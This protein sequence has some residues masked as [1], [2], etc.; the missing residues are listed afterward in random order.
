MKQ[1]KNLVLVLV[2]VVF[3]ARAQ[4]QLYPFELPKLP[5]AYNA[6]EPAVDA[7]TMEIHYS[8]HHAAYVSN[9]NAAL[10]GTEDEEYPM[11]DLLLYA[12]EFSAAVRNNAGGHYNHTLFWN[13]LLPGKP[14]DPNSDLGKAVI[15]TFGSAESLYLLLSKA[16]STRFGSGWA[17]L[18][19]T[20][21]YQLA[22][23]STPN[24]DNP[25][26]DVSP[27]RGIPIL[28]I[29]V[30]EHA[31]Y[32]KYQNK[33]GDYLRA[34]LDIINWEAVNKNYAEALKSPVMVTIARETWK[35]LSA[36]HVVMS[37]TFHPS[38][39]GNL[40]PIRERS[41]EFLER[42]KDLQKGKIPSLLDTPAIHQSIDEL[43]T[44][45]SELNQMVSNRADD[46]TL[47]K[48]LEELH[49]VFHTIQGLCRHH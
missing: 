16:G 44:G 23:S 31:Y 8:K 37:Q 24:Q 39:E 19:V 49:D 28:G 5:Y 6:L 33:R 7:A 21:E 13:I 20:P 40:Q 26:M 27:E 48:K 30:W 29:D 45:G 36:F 2:I 9:L 42:A 11:D 43:V 32:L 41:A 35:E 4:A 3:S 22:V 15:K 10:K 46:K 17:W 38:E 14:F 1:M 47:T 12:G 25:I 34:I 18:Y